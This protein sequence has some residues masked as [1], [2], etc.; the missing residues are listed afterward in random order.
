MNVFPI[1]HLQAHHCYL[2]CPGADL[3][4]V[5]R[6]YADGLGFA[7]LRKPDALRDFPVAWFDAGNMVFHIGYPATG[8]VV[9]TAHTALAT[10]DLAAAQA[11]LE[12][13][14]AAID[15]QVIDMGYP[16]FYVKDPWGNQFEI[17]PDTVSPRP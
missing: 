12:A 11:K 8:G 5:N 4:Q 14:G 17:L 15:W 10:P 3:A 1:F 7:P 9:G 13:V 6:F 2:I 16:R